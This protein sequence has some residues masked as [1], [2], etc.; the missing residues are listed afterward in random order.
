MKVADG[1][2]DSEAS[3]DWT[4]TSPAPRC[5]ATRRRQLS[6]PPAGDA[7][8]PMGG[9]ASAPAAAP[10]G[11]IESVEV[12][13]SRARRVETVPSTSHQREGKAPAVEMTVSNMTLTAPH[14]VST[15]FASRPE[16]A[17]FVG[18]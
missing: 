7:E 3:F 10:V 8:A 18:L 13:T 2:S 11:A 5:V 14:F 15:D 4:L 17:P 1:F 9:S 16:I 12:N 6:P